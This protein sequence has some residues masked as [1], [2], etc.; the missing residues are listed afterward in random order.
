MV[1]SRTRIVE[2]SNNGTARPTKLRNRVTSSD[3]PKLYRSIGQ[4]GGQSYTQ[5]N[6][7]ANVTGR[8]DGTGLVVERTEALHDVVS[9][10]SI[11]TFLSERVMFYP[12]AAGL[13]WLRNMSN[14]YSLYEIHRLEYTYVPQVPTTLAGAIGMCF[15]PD[16]LDINPTSMSQILASEQSLFAPVYAGGDGGTFLQRFGYPKGNVV[17]FEVPQHVFRT[18]SEYTKYRVTNNTGM[19]AILAAAN[20]AAVANLY[21]PGRLV[22]ASSGVGEASKNVGKIFVRYKIRLLSPIPLQ[23]QG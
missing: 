13:N 14:A 6:G 7:I 8:F 4:V 16:T 19:D 11:N 5:T 10:A 12:G 23:A 22:I 20:G 17:S 21:S 9:A 1:K 3:A 2:I 15:F 18:G